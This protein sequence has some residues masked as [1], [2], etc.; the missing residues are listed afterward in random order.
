MKYLLITALFLASLCGAQSVGAAAGNYTSS[1]QG[2]FGGMDTEIIITD[3]TDGGD[4][5]QL[6]IQT[7]HEDGA[8]DW[9]VGDMVPCPG[10]LHECWSF[11]GR[12]YTTYQGVTTYKEVDGLICYYPGGSETTDKA[13]Y[14]MDGPNGWGESGAGDRVQ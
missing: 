5:P 14:H 7:Y 4:P 13:A 10:C 8:V 2:P 12:R 9:F 1:G 3:G 11:E 6:V